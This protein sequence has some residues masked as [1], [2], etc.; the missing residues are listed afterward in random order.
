MK[1]TCKQ[2][3]DEYTK[4]RRVYEAEKLA[5]SGVDGKDVYNIA[6]P[7][8]HNDEFL[9][10][11]RVEPR[12][13]E[14]SEVVFFGFEKGTW[15]PKKDI[16]AF[17]LQDPF[18]AE[19]KGELV[20]GGVE[21]FPHPTIPGALGWRTN[22]YRGPSPD[23]LEYFASGPDGMKDIRLIELPNGR[24]GVFTRPQGEVG[25]RGTIGY[26]EIDE[27]DDLTPEICA[28]AELLHQFIPEEWGGANEVHLLKNGKLG[29]LAHIAC[30]DDQQG[31]HYYAMVFGFDPATKKA[32]PMQIIA[33]RA[34][35][36]P[37][38]SKRPDLEDVIF[39]GGLVRLPDGK[40][41]F[42][43]GLSDAEAGRILI[44]DPFV[45]YEN[46]VF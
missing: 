29:V 41:W 33:T 23:K 13:S 9:L 5:F 39:S 30:F 25:G 18:W 44:D 22:F 38:A 4:R 46:A 3:L 20:F 16:A 42:Y 35:F 8:M 10:P 27:L 15:Y 34:D 37:G 31:K 36:P 40:A 43:A 32:T 26:V 1:Q 19:I 12:E 17:R 6:A 21:V 45:D 14:Y 7:I 28:E 11:A 24:I 2:L